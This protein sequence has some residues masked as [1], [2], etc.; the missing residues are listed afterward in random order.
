LSSLGSVHQVHQIVAAAR[1]RLAEAGISRDDA[2][3]DARVLAEH[4][5]GWSRERLVTDGG[6][7]A[8][9]DFR[10]KYD[11]LVARRASREPLAYITGS[12]EFWGL[13]FEVSRAVLIPRPETELIVE[14]V[15]EL[16]PDRGTALDVADVGTGSGCLAIA[17]AK[18]RAA[19]RVVAIDN[20]ADSIAVARR[21]AER[22]GVT[23]RVELLE[24]DLLGGVS[25]MFDL[26]VANPPYV[27]DG[28]RLTLQAE[29]RDYEPASALFAGPDGLQ[30]IERL[31]AS[32]PDRLRS[33]GYLVFELGYGQADAVERLVQARANVKLIGLC[34]DLQGIPRVAVVERE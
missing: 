12:R 25:N 6:V 30:V 26:I 20:S 29:V 13:G 28:D 18:E 3:L 8:P 34:Q 2:A 14:V 31:I 19:A 16:F 23:N 5:L 24:N 21:N 32:A 1:I 10:P 4:V 11:S 7:P 33:G 15:L 17:I 27:P 9:A 22:H